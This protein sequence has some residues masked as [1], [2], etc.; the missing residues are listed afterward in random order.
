MNILAYLILVYSFYTFAHSKSLQQQDCPSVSQLSKDD[1]KCYEIIKQLAKCDKCLDSRAELKQKTARK[2][3]NL[4]DFVKLMTKKECTG[5]QYNCGHTMDYVTEIFEGIE[6]YYEVSKHF[7]G[8]VQGEE[9]AGFLKY[10][11]EGLREQFEK[12]ADSPN[13]VIYHMR[14]TG[15]HDHVWTVE[16]LPRGA[17]YRIYQ[18]YH[19]AYSLHAWLS[20]ETKGLFHADHGD[21]MIWR[22]VKHANDEGIKSMTNGKGSLLNL[23]AVKNHE[24][25]K[26]LLPFAEYVR[27]YNETLVVENFEKS[28]VQFGKGKIL[29]KDE[30][31]SYSCSSYLTK[32]ALLVGYLD[33]HDVNK[34]APYP[35]EIWDLWTELFASPP[36][37]YFPG[38][39]SNAL[40]Q[41][42]N[43]KG[44]TYRFQMKTVEVAKPECAKNARFM[45]GE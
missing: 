17:G 31:M 41:T 43:F 28:W 44:Q 38:L 16:Q 23:D 29:S 39:P 34:G 7:N 27:N 6:S 19:D 5:I 14:H 40:I 10:G 13:T 3:H 20:K 2:A 37:A 11:A 32:L 15:T 45:L 12:K 35:K 24:K 18:S 21:L 30:F 8:T 4:K 36:P 9:K 42:T 26:P 25:I 22:E 33:T 1:S